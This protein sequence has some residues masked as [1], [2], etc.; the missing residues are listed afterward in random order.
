M[1]P[2]MP[3][4]ATKHMPRPFIQR[5]D[6][7]FQNCAHAGLRCR[8]HLT[9]KRRK[10]RPQCAG[11][12]QLERRLRKL[13]PNRVA[14]RTAGFH[15]L[16]RLHTPAKLVRNNTGIKIKNDFHLGMG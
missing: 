8:H 7:R 4:P 9:F 1:Y 16:G 3:P 13:P 10:R 12:K 14:K 15:L 11:G 6:A 5:L 2:T